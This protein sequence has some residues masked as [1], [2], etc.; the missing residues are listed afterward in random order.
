M[1]TATK[2]VLAHLAN[3]YEAVSVPDVD[4]RVAAYWWGAYDPDVAWWLSMCSKIAPESVSPSLYVA[5]VAED[6]SHKRDVKDWGYIEAARCASKPP[7]GAVRQR[8]SVEGYSPAWGHQAARD[9]ISIALWGHLVEY[10]PGINHRARRY[11]CGSQAYQRIRDGVYARTSELLTLFRQDMDQC[12]NGNFNRNFADR[13]E[14]K[15][16]RPFRGL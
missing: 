1:T 11:G 4:Q 5:H 2:A 7:Q 8:A 15:T 3:V 12:C 10:I 13:W 14:M 9:G 16:G 6:L